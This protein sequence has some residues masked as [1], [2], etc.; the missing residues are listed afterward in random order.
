VEIVAKGDVIME[1]VLRD[2]SVS[3]VHVCDVLHV[4]ELRHRLISWRTLRT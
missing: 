2:G 1:C 3:S 4:S